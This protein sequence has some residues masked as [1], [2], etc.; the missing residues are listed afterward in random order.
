MPNIPF[1]FA[2]KL[3]VRIFSAR[4]FYNYNNSALV[5]VLHWI[6]TNY[7]RKSFSIQAIR[8]VFSCTV[9]HLPSYYPH[10]GKLPTSSVIPTSNSKKLVLI[11]LLH[12]A[13]AVSA[14]VRILDSGTRS[15]VYPYSFRFFCILSQRRIVLRGPFESVVLCIRRDTDDFRN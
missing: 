11:A 15:K 5:D 14:Y 2:S 10:G 8:K 1:D 3:K 7:P 9:W 12:R 6:T 13:C 4:I